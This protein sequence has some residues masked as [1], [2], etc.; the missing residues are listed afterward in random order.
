VSA[1]QCDTRSTSAGSTPPAK[2][3]TI[4]L[5]A[6]KGVTQ[7]AHIHDSPRWKSRPA[8]RAA[9]SGREIESE[10][11][12]QAAAQECRRHGRLGSRGAV[13]RSPRGGCKVVEGPISPNGWCIAYVKKG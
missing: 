2:A 10:D 11:V 1:E 5:G 9:T 12:T 6:R 4:D 7:P 8:S 3:A 13:G